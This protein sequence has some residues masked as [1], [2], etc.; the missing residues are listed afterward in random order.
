MRRARPRLGVPA[1]ACVAALGIA[2]AGCEP[3]PRG[4]SDLSFE[5]M[6]DSTAEL[7]RGEPVLRAF[8][9][10]RMDNGALRVRGRVDLPDGTRLQVAVRRPGERTTVQMVQVF[11]QGGQFDSPPM[12]GD[13]GPL[14]VERYQFEVLAHFTPEWQTPQVL[15]ATG[16]GRALRGP[17]I[18]RTRQGAATFQRVE[19]ARI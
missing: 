15:R 12:I 1:L 17:G 6:P 14:P 19:E 2:L 18:T 13:R 8:E 9:P 10:Y 11:V 4:D 16:D 7:A 3:K 5:R